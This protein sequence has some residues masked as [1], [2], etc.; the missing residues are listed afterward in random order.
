MVFGQTMGTSYSI[1]YQGA[2]N[3]KVQIDSLL[4]AIN[5]SV[6]TYEPESTIAQINKAQ[7][8]QTIPTDS[9]FDMNY[10]A[11]RKIL[12]RTNGI[13]N[14]GVMPLVNYYGFGF[15]KVELSKIDTQKVTD[16]QKLVRPTCFTWE[17]GS[18]TKHCDGAMLDFSSLAKGYGVDEV[19]RFLESKGIVNYLV[20]IGGETYAEGVNERGSNWT[21]GV[22]KPTIDT[23]ERLAILQAFPL[24]QQA[25]ATSGNYENFKALEGGKTI[26][27]MI[28]PQTG[29]PQA[30]DHEVLSSTVFAPNCMM[31]DGYATAIKIMGLERGLE[32]AE[33]TADVEAFLVYVDAAGNFRSRSTTGL[34]MN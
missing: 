5:A 24:D 32:L 11:A 21:V 25:M 22:R 12:E 34:D 7:P 19:A 18:I 16:L 8:N 23:D 13:Y 20:E 1:K 3:Y 14:P 31:A 15:E 27:H 29:F 10:E 33:K 28:N 17:S 9:H 4:I 6:S 26:A 30:L 2:Q